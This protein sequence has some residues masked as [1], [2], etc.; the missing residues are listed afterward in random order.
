LVLTCPIAAQAQMSD[1]MHMAP[2]DTT[3]HRTSRPAAHAHAK[4]ASH[5]AKQAMPSIHHGMHGMEM[6][7]TG[8]TGGTS[9]MGGMGGMGGMDMGG[10]AMSGMYGP[11]AMT[12]EASGTAW[13]PDAARHQGLHTMKGA[14][15]VMVHGFADAVYDDQG[16]PRGHSKAF[17]NNMGMLM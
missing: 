3:S 14:W 5:A 1:H 11:Y 9:G 10:M 12:R 16:G 7:G 17:S 4:N 15:M 2:R 6:G 13:Q 8:G